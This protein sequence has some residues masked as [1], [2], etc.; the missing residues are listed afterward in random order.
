MRLEMLG[1]AF[2]SQH[3]DS[4]V[5]EHLVYKWSHSACSPFQ[6]LNSSFDA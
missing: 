5:L 4:R 1:S 6:F 2:T 3:S